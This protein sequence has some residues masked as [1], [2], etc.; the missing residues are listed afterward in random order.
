MLLQNSK[1]CA[2]IYSDG[3]FFERQ[4]KTAFDPANG[5]LIDELFNKYHKRLHGIINN[6]LIEFKW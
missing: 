3:A 5:Y 4:N 6:I 2:I 1:K